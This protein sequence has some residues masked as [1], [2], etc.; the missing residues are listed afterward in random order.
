M[1]PGLEN[2][3]QS[4][5]NVAG[6]PAGARLS[7]YCSMV[8]RGRA[9]TV[10][11]LLQVHNAVKLPVQATAVAR[12]TNCGGAAA[13]T[14]AA[15]LLPKAYCQRP[16]VVEGL[17]LGRTIAVDLLLQNHCSRRVTLGVVAAGL[18]YGYHL[19]LQKCCC[20]ATCCRRATS[21]AC[22]F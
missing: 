15:D 1:A 4:P 14:A 17:L 3:R 5:T 12:W 19:L 13:A 21:A 20:R 10:R 2:G 22:E 9:C 7:G 11:L 18:L 8:C 16:T 6:L